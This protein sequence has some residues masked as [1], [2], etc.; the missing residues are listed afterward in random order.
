MC[1]P[2]HGP[3]APS[4]SVLAGSATTSSGSTSIRMPRPVQS[5]QAPHGELNE[6]D[7]G[8]SS[9]KDSRRRGR[10]GARRH[11]LPVR[12]VSGR[13]TKS[14]TTMPPDSPSAVSTE[15]VE[16]APGG[17]LDV[18]PVDH[19]LDVVLLVL[20]QRGQGSGGGA[21]QPD[22]RA[23]HPGPG[24]PLGL[25]FTQQLGVLTLAA[26]T[27]ARAPGTWCPRQAR[28]TRSTIC[29]GLCL[30]IGPP[31]IGQCGLPTRAYSSRR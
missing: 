15:S 22:H 23:V 20:L 14:S 18:E 10:P 3:I 16:P 27:T 13:S 21:V 30:A 31:Q 2:L 28:S 7:R 24:I 19:D 5:G 26:R 4:A 1:P 29:C 8:S 9:S 17:L 12:S 6:N 11:P 25:Q